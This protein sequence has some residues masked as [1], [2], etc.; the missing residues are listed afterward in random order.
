MADP[1]TQPL[2]IELDRERE[3]QIRWADGRASLCPLPALR[4]ACPCAA[5]RTNREQE[6]MGVLPVVRDSGTQRDMVCACS[7]HL[8]GN[9]ALRVTWKDG[10]DSGIYD[11]ALLRSLFPAEVPLTAEDTRGGL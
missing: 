4:R 11:F 5:C 1:A 2:E 3:L 8:V 10:H 7:A 9:Y 6:V